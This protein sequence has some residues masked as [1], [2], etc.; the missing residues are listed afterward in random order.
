MNQTHIRKEAIF[1][2]ML[3]ELATHSHDNSTSFQWAKNVESPHTA[4]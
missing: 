2:R 1:P 4:S 3:Q